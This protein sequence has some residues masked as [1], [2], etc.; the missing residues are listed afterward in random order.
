MKRKFIIYTPSF[1]EFN[2]GVIVLHKLCDMLKKSGEKSYLWSYRKPYYNLKTLFMQKKI[3]L[4]Y[5]L[6]KSFREFKTFEKFNTPLAKYCDLED[7]IVV[8]PEI[9][10]D[11]PLQSKNIVRWFLYKP[12]VVTGKIN[13]TDNELYFYFQEAFNDSTI[14]PNS[15]NKLQISHLRDDIY[16]HKKNTTRKGSCYLLKKGR[17]R[18]IIH[19]LKDSILIDDLS[20]EKISEIFNSVKYFISYDTYS[21]YSRYAVLC[22]C[23]S[24]VVPEKG[25]DKE[26]WRP[27]E[28]L[29]Y[30]IAYGFD[31][32]DYANKTKK[33][34]YSSLKKQEKESIISVKKFI[35]KCENHF[36]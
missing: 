21:M 33:Y 26:N 34:V 36:G 8:Y 22:G 18:K 30:G 3:K 20:H 1:D 25:V 13:Y 2:G 15:N 35:V 16:F 19:N 14:N 12:G 23:T 32:L 24:I 31:D 4:N 11:N 10:L 7:S 5:L 28:E 29:R 27:E 17:N 9:I 6:Q